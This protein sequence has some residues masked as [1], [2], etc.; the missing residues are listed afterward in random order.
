MWLDGRTAGGLVSLRCEFNCLSDPFDHGELD[1]QN[2][3]F[4]VTESWWRGMEKASDPRSSFL[5]AHLARC[6]DLQTLVEA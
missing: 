3:T 1:L 5:S 4:T 2:A 6:C